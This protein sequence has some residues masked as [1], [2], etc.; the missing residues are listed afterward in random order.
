[1]QTHC[2]IHL[3]RVRRVDSCVDAAFQVQGLACRDAQPAVHFQ[4]VGQV[5][6]RRRT[7]RYIDSCR[8]GEVRLRRIVRD[9]HHQ[10][11]G[12]GGGD[13]F[14][15]RLLL[16]LGLDGRGL[17]WPHRVLG[18]MLV[19]LL[20]RL[21]NILQLPADLLLVLLQPLIRVP[22]PV[23]QVDAGLRIDL[24]H[25]RRVRLELHQD[26]AVDILPLE[27]VPED[28][29][30]VAVPVLGIDH[31]AGPLPCGERV[32]LGLSGHRVRH[33]DGHRA[34]QDADLHRPLVDDLHPA[35][36]PP[37]PHHDGG[38]ADV[39]GLAVLHGLGD[40]EEDVALVQQELQLL[41]ALA[42]LH[43][44]ESVQLVELGAVQVDPGVAGLLRLHMVAAVE[45]HLLNER[46]A[47][48]P[49]VGDGHDALRLG[50]LHGGGGLRRQGRRCAAEQHGERQ[51]Q[52]R[53]P[54]VRSFFSHDLP[55][56]KISS[57]VKT[58]NPSFFPFSFTVPK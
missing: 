38:G 49:V 7:G 10:T 14:L 15:K 51:Q 21:L 19:L 40:V 36:G 46:D 13:G 33:G 2:A 22:G 56:A 25:Q 20:Q 35:A 57:K 41:P 39:Q 1:M 58:S 12:S 27:A 48:P 29:A 6:L 11:L 47:A 30:L 16:R 31:A 34:L 52:G 18:D 50:Q 8:G 24:L 5:V 28:V 37:D 43:L 55:S 3:Q 32:L 9:F 23:P 4:H 53:Q 45:A 42:D 54:P 17:L 26:E 44:A